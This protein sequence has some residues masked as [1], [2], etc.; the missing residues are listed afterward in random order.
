MDLYYYTKLILLKLTVNYNNMNNLFQLPH[1]F[2]SF[3]YNISMQI[4]KHIHLLAKQYFLLLQY[5]ILN[6]YN[7]YI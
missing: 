1:F 7:N 5:Q 6:L 3:L 2:C 4:I